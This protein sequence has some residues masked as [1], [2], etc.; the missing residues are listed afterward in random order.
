VG[1]KLV[2][3]RSLDVEDTRGVRLIA[4]IWHV[5]IVRIAHRCVFCF[6]HYWF[7]RDGR[8]YELRM[9]LDGFGRSLN[10]KV[11]RM[12]LLTKTRDSEQREHD[13][14]MTMVCISFR[15]TSSDDIIKMRK[16]FCI[17]FVSRYMAEQEN[18]HRPTSSLWL[19]P[20]N[21]IQLYRRL[22]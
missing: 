7:G 3:R 17:L 1:T 2:G 6:S 13:H 14:S 15:S 10:S 9:S 8:I 21:M 16:S 11:C 12:R 22:L 5:C 18:S 4:S 20:C 19:L